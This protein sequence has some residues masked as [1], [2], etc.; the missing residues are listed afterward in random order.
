[1]AQTTQKLF[2]DFW[3]YFVTMRINNG[4]VLGFSIIPK[5]LRKD[6]LLRLRSLCKNSSNDN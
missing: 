3:W 2:V 4:S 1:M 6:N 5:K